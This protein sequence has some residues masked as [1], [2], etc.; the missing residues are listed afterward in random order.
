[1][2][3]TDSSA[4]AQWRKRCQRQDFVYVEVRV[5][6]K[7]ADLVR[8]VTTTLEELKREAEAHTITREKIPWICVD[9]LKSLL[10]SAPLDD[11]DF[12]RL[13]DFGRN[14]DQ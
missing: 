14:L 3:N 2:A 6:E 1:M 10:A 5:C 7:D 12:D 9:G 8:Y 4:V 13:R 11:I